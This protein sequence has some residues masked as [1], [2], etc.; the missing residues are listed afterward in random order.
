MDDLPAARTASYTVL[1][2]GYS[3]TG[4]AST[5]GYAE[6]GEVRLVIDPGIVRDRTL[7]LD[8]LWMM[9]VAPELISDV[10]FSHHHPEHTLNAALFPNARFHDHRTIYSGDQRV[11]R[12]AEGYELTRSIK[13]IRTPGHTHED[14]TTLVGTPDG[15][16]AF[17]H[18]WDDAASAEDEQAVDLEALHLGRKR[19]LAVADVVVP[20]HGAAFIPE[21]TTAR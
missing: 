13:L 2:E 8:A 15:I 11:L 18:L 9:G 19:V 21:S 12:D 3:G 20:G 17:T 6:D 1:Y 10:V 4:L 7:I 16:V 5:V 14:V